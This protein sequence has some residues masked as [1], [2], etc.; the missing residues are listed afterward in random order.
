MSDDTAVSMPTIDFWKEKNV[1]VTGATGLVGKQLIEK[2]LYS[3]QVQSVFILIRSTKGKTVAERHKHY[4]DD[5][6]FKFRLTP[7]QLGKIRVIEGDISLPELG[8][9]A[10]DRKLLIE[11][12]NVVIH[13]AATVRF[14][15]PLSEAMNLNVLASLKMLDLAVEMQNLQSFVYV[16]TAFSNF[17]TGILDDETHEPQIDPELVL[18]MMQEQDEETFDKVTAPVIM[19]PHPNT[20]IFSKNIAEYLIRKEA[21]KRCLPLVI[22]KPGIITAPVSE[23]IPGFSDSSAQLPNKYMLGMI[24][25]VV[26][27]MYALPEASFPLAPVDYVANSIIMIAAVRG[28]ESLAKSNVK[29]IRS[30]VILNTSENHFTVQKQLEYGEPLVLADLSSKTIRTP[31][32]PTMV[33]NENS[34]RLLRIYYDFLFVIFFDLLLWITGRKPMLKKVMQKTYKAIDMS[35]VFMKTIWQIR[36]ENL[37]HDFRSLSQIEQQFYALDCMDHIDW[38]QYTSDSY[39]SL[40][41]YYLKETEKSSEKMH[42]RLNRINLLYKLFLFM[43]VCLVLS[44]A[45][46]VRYFVL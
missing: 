8:I 15:G 20:Y 41:M 31:C 19:D 23:P 7:D 30:Y 37:M 35:S 44:I 5:Q 3:T 21:I 38:N 42:H 9:S 29:E 33:Q 34:I 14:D 11:Q 1:F 32:A 22:A 25:G 2:L 28:L 10:D 45:L 17:Y 24:T 36:A 40:K 39:K 4:I 46:L 26:R 16:G 18:K 43:L 12:V 13:S 27:V 6:L